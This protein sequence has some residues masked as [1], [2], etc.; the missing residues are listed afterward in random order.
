MYTWLTEQALREIYLRP[1]EIA[2]RRG[3][4]NAIMTS[5]GRIGA[6]W[7]GGSEA[8]LTEVCREEWGF[9]GAFL[10]DYADH[11]DFMNGDQMIRAGGDIWM[12]GWNSN[13]SFTNSMK[14]TTAYKYALRNATKNVLY[15]WM[16]TLATN[17]TYNESADDI[18]IP[19]TPELNF[20]WY[21]PVIIVVDV[22]L[23]AG[24]G[25]LIFF[26][27]RKKDKPVT[28]AAAESTASPASPTDDS[29]TPNE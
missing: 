10:T 9:K 3:G 27:I 15:M 14:S 16:N 24:A 28:E 13:G 1:F 5:Y 29:E 11:H 8:L 23:A 6:V 4:S 17:A 20:R 2:V 26:A 25:V 18:V 19:V 7:T 12:D 21:I 22:L